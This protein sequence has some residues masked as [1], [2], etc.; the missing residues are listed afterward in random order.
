M[1]SGKSSA[2]ATQASYDRRMEEWR[3]QASQ[4]DLELSQLDKQIAAAVV[5]VAIAV[6][7]LE[8]HEQQ[9]ENAREVEE[10]LQD[11]FTNEALY[12]WMARQVASLYFESY[13]LAFD[14]ARKAERAYQFERLAPEARFVQFGHWDNL[15]RGLLAGERLHLDLR[16]MEHAYLEQNRR[17]L[18]M[19]KHVSLAMNSPEALLALKRTGNCAFSVP[20]SLFDL[21]YP[22]HYMRR[23]KAVSMTIPAAVGP[24]AGV[25]ATLTLTKSTVRRSS[26]PGTGYGSA[27]SEDPRFV[28]QRG[29]V[30]SICTSSG[31][32]DGG[33]FQLDFRDERYLPFEGAGADSEWALTLRARDN[34][35]DLSTL[36]DVILHVQYTARDGGEVLRN[37][38]E[39]HRESGGY[40]PRP[41]YRVFSA[42]QHFPTAWQAFTT[43]LT[44]VATQ[45]D[46]TLEGLDAR[47]PAAPAG[48]EVFVTQVM[49]LPV[50]G[51]GTT[52]V[53]P[54]LTLRRPTAPSGTSDDPMT[55]EAAGPLAGLY[56]AAFTGGVPAPGKTAW[57]L[58]MAATRRSPPPER[59]ARW[60][61]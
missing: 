42:R 59:R 21:D 15:K 49:A 26:L 48:G 10:F 52:P 38:A 31:Q 58:R 13:R 43:S 28:V 51:V 24:Y 39:E 20:E 35:F 22:G 46:L 16:R 18:E 3:H 33:V 40:D 6:R 56:R 45:V 61:S 8:N 25:H 60:T 55:P 2:V 7:E 14:L 44:T 29:A 5:R 23:I 47:L 12:D 9:I 11:K 53:E 50:L 17:D 4:A 34:D 30:E 19:T 37:A 36:T 57:S 32:N 54:S 1:L 27:G 41:E